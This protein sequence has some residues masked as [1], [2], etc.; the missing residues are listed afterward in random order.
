MLPPAPGLLSTTTCWPHI[1]ESRAP[2]MRPTASMPP[3]GVNGTTSLTTRFGQ[4]PCASAAP[5]AT[6]GATTGATAEA[7]ATRIRPRRSSMTLLLGLDPGGLDDRTP[8]LG[9]RP[10]PRIEFCR[11]RRHDLDADPSEAGLDRG[12][13][14]DCD[15]VDV[16]LLDDVGGRFG[17]HE[18]C[19]PRGDVEAGQRIR[20][21]WK[22]WR[23]R[24]ALRGADRESAQLPGA[25][26]LQHASRRVEHHVNTAGDHVVE[27]GRNAAIGYVRHLKTRHA[28]KQFAGEMRRSADAR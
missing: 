14:K 22:L 18:E 21:G 19:I 7:A 4:P 2:M 3:P 11:R 26:L 24:K 16:D 1:S 13:G 12:L 15:G 6:K 28:L 17:G 8:L 25:Y 5:G 27:R 10:Q 23:G 9:F 20:N